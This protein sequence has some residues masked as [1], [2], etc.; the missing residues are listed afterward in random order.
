M[1]TNDYKTLEKAHRILERIT[2]PPSPLP[3][4][5]K[6]RCSEAYDGLSGVLFYVERNPKVLKGS[7]LYYTRFRIRRIYYRIFFGGMYSNL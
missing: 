2:E 1:T 7:F 3:P 4:S 6:D 5:L